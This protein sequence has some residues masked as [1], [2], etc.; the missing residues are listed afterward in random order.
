ML[1]T[2]KEFI[3]FANQCGSG[4]LKEW[5]GRTMWATFSDSPHIVQD[6][7]RLKLYVKS[8]LML[9]GFSDR[10]CQTVSM[11]V[12]ASFMTNHLEQKND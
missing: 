12:Y 5:K 1:K 11:M 4:H 10:S 7:S 8:R 6:E 3:D 2:D 9:D